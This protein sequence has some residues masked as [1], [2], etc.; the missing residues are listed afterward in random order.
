M[1][2]AGIEGVSRRRFRVG[3]TTPGGEATAAPDLVKRDFTAALPDELWYADIH[4]RTVI[5][6]LSEGTAARACQ[7]H[8][9]GEELGRVGGFRPRLANCVIETSRSG[10]G[11]GGVPRHR[12]ARQRLGRASISLASISDEDDSNRMNELR[13]RSV[14]LSMSRSAN[15]TSREFAMSSSPPPTSLL[16]MGNFSPSLH[17]LFPSDRQGCRRSAEETTKA[18]GDDAV[19]QR[20]SLDRQR[21]R[22]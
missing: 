9:L 16:Q 4:L 6:D 8:R 11:G 17:A 19:T 18:L 21:L 14:R 10:V 13:K 5:G 12:A 7:A 2:A 20:Q 22:V 15:M 1:R 3:T